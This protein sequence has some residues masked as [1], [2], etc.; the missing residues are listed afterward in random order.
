MQNSLN[1]IL[2]IIYSIYYYQW[3]LIQMRSEAVL[4]YKLLLL[5]SVQ[6]TFPILAL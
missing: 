2:I 1:K 6:P 3:Y 5:F 4:R